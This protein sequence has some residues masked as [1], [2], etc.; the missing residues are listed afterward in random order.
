M[1]LRL[2]DETRDKFLYIKADRIG[3]HR[4]TRHYFDKKSDKIMSSANKFKISYDEKLQKY[5]LAYT[6]NNLWVLDT[7]DL[8]NYQCLVKLEDYPEENNPVKEEPFI[9]RLLVIEVYNKGSKLKKYIVD[10]EFAHV[11]VDGETFV[12]LHKELLP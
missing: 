6:L 10:Q 11:Y 7:S 8:L 2:F 3:V 9:N 4:D 12:K 5:R 1:L